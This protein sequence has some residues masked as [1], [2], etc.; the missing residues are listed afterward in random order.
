MQPTTLNLLA[1]P[2][3]IFPTA[4]GAAGGNADNDDGAYNIDLDSRKMTRHL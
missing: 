4:R 1:A 2:A 3:S